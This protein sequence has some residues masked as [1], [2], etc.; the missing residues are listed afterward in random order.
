MCTGVAPVML[1]LVRD[2]VYMYRG[3]PGGVVS[4]QI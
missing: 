3:G 4:S 2:E 1:C